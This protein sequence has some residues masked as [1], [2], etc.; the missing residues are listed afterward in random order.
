LLE[1][2]D[3]KPLD[4]TAL[5]GMIPEVDF[6]ERMTVT[7]NTGCNRFTGRAVLR[8]EFFVIERRTSTRRACM[9]AQDEIERTVR[10]ML[11]SESVIT[12]GADR[13]LIL[14]SEQT[15]LRFRLFEWR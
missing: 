14:R 1:S 13:Q 12:I 2:I 11:G 3:D 4:T 10:Q 8:E 6:G 9:G 5:G 7:G 15:M